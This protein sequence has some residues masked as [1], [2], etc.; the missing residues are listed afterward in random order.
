[1]DDTNLFREA[2]LKRLVAS[3][4]E[5]SLKFGKFELR[6][7]AISDYYLDLRKLALS[8]DGLFWI[9][10][11]IHDLLKVEDVGR[12]FKMEFDA[13]GGPC[14]GA[15][16]IVGAFLYN[17]G[18]VK[19]HVRGFLVRKE[20][21]THGDKGMVIGS[22]RPGDK[23]VVVEDVCSTGGSLLRACQLIQEF[24]CEVVLAACVVD[25]LAGAKQMFDSVGINYKSLL[26]IDDLEIDNEIQ[27]EIENSENFFLNYHVMDI[28][29]GRAPIDVLK[30]YDLEV[31][32]MKEWRATTP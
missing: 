25:R 20:E 22:V 11:G 2:S 8:S 5:H 32:P 23:V 26:T 13:I 24:G 4:K 29:D 16:P 1:M 7:G 3:I 9:V 12:K 27:A 28:E 17:Q 21:K 14:I 18:R 15:D 31:K 6:S 10:Y 19:H 30:K